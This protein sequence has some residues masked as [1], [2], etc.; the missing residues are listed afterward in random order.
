[1]RTRINS[2][3]E[4]MDEITRMLRRKDLEELKEIEEELRFRGEKNHG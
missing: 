3:A 2:K 1:M 4:V